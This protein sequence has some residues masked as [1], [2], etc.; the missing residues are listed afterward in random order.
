MGKKG[1]KILKEDKE[2][3]QWSEK[4]IQKA[5]KWQILSPSTIKYEIENLN[6]F[7]WESDS[8]FITRSGYIYECEIK[9]SR[10]DFKHDFKKK[11][12]HLILEGKDNFEQSPNYFYYVVPKDL[13]TVDEIPEYAGL[14]Y[15]DVFYDFNGKISGYPIKFVKTAPII[16]KDKIDLNT[17]NLTDKFYFN[18][19]NWKE[20][21]KNK[22]KQIENLEKEIK[23]ILTSE[24][25][26]AYNYNLKESKKIIDEQNQRIDVLKKQIN[27]E[28]Y[29][30]KYYFERSRIFQRLLIR[31]YIDYEQEVKEFNEKFDKEYGKKIDKK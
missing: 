11:K 28:E 6:V 5:I 29:N 18:Y 4:V 30:S 17:L 23:N 10:G 1:N 12:K 19:I 27:D 20:V 13:I 3:P 7:D 24:S 21:A 14:I 22:D 16:H 31:N 26:V 15:V 25:D 8:L 2:Q 9:I